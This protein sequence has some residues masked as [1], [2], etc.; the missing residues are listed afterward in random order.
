MP[1]RFWTA[2][3]TMDEGEI[4][5]GPEAYYVKFRQWLKGL[6]N[7][8]MQILLVALKG[9]LPFYYTRHAS[10]HLCHTQ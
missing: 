10:S 6:A 1:A 9:D 3:V 4:A 8:R 7:L 5:L 2:L